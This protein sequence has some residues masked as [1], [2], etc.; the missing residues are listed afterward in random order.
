MGHMGDASESLPP[1][2]EGGNAF[3]VFEFSELAGG[4]TFAEEGEIA[5]L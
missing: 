2:P 4:E 1:E 3:Q 5:H